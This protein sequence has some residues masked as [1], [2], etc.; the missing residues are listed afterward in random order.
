MRLLTPGDFDIETVEGVDGPGEFLYFI[1]SPGDATRRYLY[2]ARLDGRGTP[3]ARHAAEP[4]G[5]AQLQGLPRRARRDPHGLG[6]RPAARDRPRA[7][8]RRTRRS[9]C[10][11]TTGSSPPR[12]RPSVSPATEF[13]RVDIGGGVSLDGWMVKPRNFDPSKKYPLLM[14]VY[15]EPAGVEAT[16]K[17]RG[18]PTYRMLFHRALA[19]AGYVVACVDNRGTPSLKG[20]DWRK[21][22]YGEVGVLAAEDQA[23]AVRALLASKSFLDPERVASWGW[24][25]GGQMTLHALFRYPDLYKVGMVVSS[26]TDQT[27]YDT[28]Y[29]ERYMG[30]PQDNAEGYRKGSPISYA[31]GLKGKLL[32][33]HGSGD[34]NVHYQGT[35][36][37]INRLVVLE[38]A[39]RL[40]GLP[41]PH[42]LDQRGRGHVVPPARADGAPPAGEP[43][44]RSA[45][46]PI[47]G[48]GT[49]PGPPAH[50][51]RG[52]SR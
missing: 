32:L 49:V 19:D 3:G 16:D 21:S 43:E 4:A 6:N 9:A 22:V 11:R 13:F 20:R 50:R 33:V 42:A 24:S 29:Q 38:Q 37:L 7:A 10:S 25:G 23:A 46:T 35:E 17:W 30:L 44:A 8:A 39:V 45:P 52:R 18:D 48:A 15:G 51:L 12:S 34:D 27:L 1:A 47:V 40:H 28:I 2:R 41:E 14:Y 31:E 26:V 5:L 36:R